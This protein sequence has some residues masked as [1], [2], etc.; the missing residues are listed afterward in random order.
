MVKKQ[1]KGGI[2]TVKKQHKRRYRDS[3][4]AGTG[5]NR[6][7]KQVVDE[8]EKKQIARCI[9]EALPDWFGIPEA[10][11]EYIR[12]SVGKDFFAVYNEE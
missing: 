1:Y 2:K 9:L 12:E 11:E 5:R 10:R 3:I 4:K 7:I 6:M 8:E